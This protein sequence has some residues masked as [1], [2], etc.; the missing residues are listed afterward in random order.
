[1]QIDLPQDLVERIQ[2]RRS[3]EQLESDA[4]A[5]RKALDVLDWQDQERRAIQEG[6]EAWCAGDTQDLDEFDTEFRAQNGIP[7]GDT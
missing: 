4:E 6:I 5:I 7:R 2:K 3:I 1:M